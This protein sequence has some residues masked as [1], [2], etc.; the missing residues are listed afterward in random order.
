[1]GKDSFIF[2]DGQPGDDSPDLIRAYD[3]ELCE[4]C[5]FAA[6]ESQRITVQINWI[7]W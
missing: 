2:A 1:M 3:R 6:V 5:G 4:V 7:K